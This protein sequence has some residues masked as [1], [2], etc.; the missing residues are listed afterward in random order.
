MG[1]LRFVG[2]PSGSCL[3]CYRCM[4]KVSQE[5]VESDCPKDKKKMFQR[6]FIAPFPFETYPIGDSP[7]FVYAVRRILFCHPWQ[8]PGTGGQKT[9]FPIY[10]RAIPTS[11][12]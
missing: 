8:L 5:T 7:N 3:H 10:F 1:R 6:K 2:I 4:A 12:S 9:N 11:C